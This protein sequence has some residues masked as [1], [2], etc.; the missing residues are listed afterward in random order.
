[1]SKES[2]FKQRERNGA[3]FP[4]TPPRRQ[5]SLPGPSSLI[6]KSRAIQGES[7]PFSP[8]PFSPT[9][10]SRKQRTDVVNVLEKPRNASGRTTTPPRSSIVARRSLSPNPFPPFDGP[11]RSSTPEYSQNE[12]STV[13]KA[14]KRLRGDI[15]SP[16]PARIDKKRRT[17]AVGSLPSFQTRSHD[18]TQASSEPRLDN[19]NEAETSFIDESP[20]KVASSGKDFKLLFD[21]GLPRLNFEEPR[22]SRSKISKQKSAVWP[23][24]HRHDRIGSANTTESRTLPN[25]GLALGTKQSS[26]T[27]GQ[28]SVLNTASTSGTQQGIHTAPVFARKRSSSDAET[29]TP[30]IVNSAQLESVDRLLPPSPQPTSSTLPKTSGKGTKAMKNILPN[31]K[32]TK[33]IPNDN[34]DASEEDDLVDVQIFEAE[35]DLRNRLKARN[36]TDDD[37][38]LG[39]L[40]PFARH[41]FDRTLPESEI[42]EREELEINLPDCLRSVLHIS[43]SRAREREER[44]LVDSLLLG[45]ASVDKYGEVWGVGEVEP[46]TAVTDDEDDWAGEGVPWEAAEL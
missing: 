43:P 1:M 41:G 9:K 10:A 15:V 17:A 18:D 12:R 24:P 28:G 26:V 19:L 6:P 16:S 23:D 31:R 3:V 39:I 30:D 5:A 8:N 36:R 22:L 37:P 35:R 7:D 34:S 32:K 11:L 25:K 13:K 2:N 14:R 21:E 29:S 40:T 4:V 33:L 46:S 20:M 45:E 44:A 27:F 38:D 42:S